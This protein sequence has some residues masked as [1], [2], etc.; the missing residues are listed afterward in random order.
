MKKSTQILITLMLSFSFVF[1]IIGY[2]QLTDTLTVHGQLEAAPLQ[3]LYIVSV[4]SGG[5]NA[6]TN[7]YT[8]TVHSSTVDLGASS[9]GTATF[10][11]TVLNNTGYTYY[12]DKMVWADDA[13]DNTNIVPTLNGIKAKYE[14]LNGETVT[15]TV[16]FS[17]KNASNISNTVLNSVINYQFVP[18]ADDAGDIAVMNVLDKFKEILNDE[19]TGGAFEKLIENMEASGR[20]ANQ[21]YIGNVVGADSED[22]KIVEE[23]F[24]DE[25]MNYLVLPI[26]DNKNKEVTAIIKRAALDGDSTTGTNIVDNNGNVTTAGCEMTI[27]L[28]PDDIPEDR[29]F[30][31]SGG[32]SITVYAAVF[33]TDA[34][35]NWYQLSPLYAGKATTNNYDGSLFSTTNSFNTDTWRSSAGTYAMPD[36]TSVTVSAD[37]TIQTLTT[38]LVNEKK[39]N[40]A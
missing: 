1:S 10:T 17:Y 21:T 14:L 9:S 38:A 18:N 22:T 40:L 35:G 33:T 28:T 37:Q 26:G 11:I 23:L 32:R 4:A 12:F 8:K 15:F 31:G 6:Q 29:L 25:I 30:F 19:T 27:Y 3:D 7:A 36:G 5:S 16:T 39:K 34:E 20:R 24:T 13:Y 2:A